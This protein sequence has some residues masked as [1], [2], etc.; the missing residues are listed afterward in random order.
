MVSS[1][2]LVTVLRSVPAGPLDT[3]ASAAIRHHVQ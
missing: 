3:I 2:V 1:A